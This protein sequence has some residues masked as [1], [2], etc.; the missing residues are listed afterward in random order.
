[1]Y[2]IDVCTYKKNRVYKDDRTEVENIFI[3]K[4]YKVFSELTELLIN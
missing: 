1:M 2:L 3:I 4:K